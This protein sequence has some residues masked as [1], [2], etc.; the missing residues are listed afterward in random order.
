L[1]TRIVSY[2]LCIA[3]LCLEEFPMERSIVVLCRQLCKHTSYLLSVVRLLGLGRIMNYPLGP[4]QAT[5]A[6]AFRRACHLECRLLRS[7]HPS[8]CAVR[9]R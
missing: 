8:L 3:E 7:L 6:I 9:D 1:P 2:T 4:P 5:I